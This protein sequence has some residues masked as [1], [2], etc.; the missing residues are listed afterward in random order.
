MTEKKDLLLDIQNLTVHYETDSGV[1]HAVEGLN[2][3]LG[4]G[5]SLGF[6]GETGAGKTTTALAIMQLI[7]NPPGK[8]LN[9]NIIFDG[10]NL[11]TLNEEEKRHIRGGKIAMIFQD[12][13]TSLNPVIPVGEQIAE[14]IELHQNVTKDEAFKKAVQMLELVGI[15]PER[16]KDF[17]HQFSG[18]M[19]QRVVIAI[20]LACDPTL[21]IAD[22]P[23]TAL[24]VTIQAQVLEL[25]K[26]LK[27]EFNTSMIMITHDLG[28]VA[29][30]CDK[31]AI[32]YAGSVVEY[33]DTRVLYTNPLHPYTNGL[34]NSIP[35]LDEDEEELKVIQGLMPDPTNLP[36]G[37]T[38][39]PRC[40]LAQPECSQKKPEMI[41]IEPGHFVA[42]P[43]CCNAFV[44][45][46]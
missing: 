8:I 10:Q 1:V 21:L 41:E 23:T 2:L 7:P 28:V 19:R 26:E 35:D 16:A 42:C 14:M 40:P 29:E 46:G 38:F 43:V 24:D 22:E 11:N 13:M 18:G 33:A 31:V 4:H 36:S 6:V 25:M 45:K 15:R 37:C 30:I 27:K 34:F 32:M 44:K 39:H 12:P 20:A 17:P 5:E 9:G 3:Q